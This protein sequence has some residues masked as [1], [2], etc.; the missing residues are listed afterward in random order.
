MTAPTTNEFLLRFPEFGEQPTSVVESALAEASRFTPETVWTTTHSEGV[1]YL[2]AHILGSR[3]VQ[4]GQQ[5]GSPAGNPFGQV[6]MSTL[7][8]QEYTR[9]RDALPLTGFVA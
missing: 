9:L 6:L 8:G 2:A 5:V 3:T 7:Y 4:V 1:S